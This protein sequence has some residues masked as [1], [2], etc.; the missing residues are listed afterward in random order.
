MN[1]LK[2]LRLVDLRL[3]GFRTKG[4]LV[5]ICDPPGRAHVIEKIRRQ[6]VKLKLFLHGHLSGL[7]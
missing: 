6:P 3:T 4:S 1:L 7:T 2:Q 5:L